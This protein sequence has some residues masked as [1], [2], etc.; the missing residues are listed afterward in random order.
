[1]VGVILLDP[2]KTIASGNL[3]QL[4]DDG[5][6]VFLGRKPYFTDT[7]CVVAHLAPPNR[8]ASAPPLACAPRDPA[9]RRFCS[10]ESRRGRALTVRG[11]HGNLHQAPRPA[12]GLVRG[13]VRA[14][15]GVRPPWRR[16][17]RG[18]VPA[19]ARGRAPRGPSA[20]DAAAAAVAEPAQPAAEGVA[21]GRAASVPLRGA[22][23]VR[24]FDG[25]RGPVCGPRLSEGSATR[26]TPK[27]P[28][29][30]RGRRRRSAPP[31]RC[32]EMEKP[33]ELGRALSRS[34]G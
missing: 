24:A 34:I 17:V 7:G 1:M 16:R 21:G 11:L 18:R 32:R 12:R 8:T 3:L 23:V 29:G 19:L 2:A 27:G 4:F 13:S 31:G 28:W 9:A 20:V 6:E 14:L 26:A 5:F 10:G 22:S 33:V 15:D 30:S 25:R